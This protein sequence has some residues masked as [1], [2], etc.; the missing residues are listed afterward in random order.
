MNGCYLIKKW[1]ASPLTSVELNGSMYPIRAL[2]GVNDSRFNRL[3][4]E[5]ASRSVLGVDEEKMKEAWSDEHTYLDWADSA[6][7]GFFC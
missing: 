6:C 5:R 2:T 1:D 3:L 4:Q 7:R